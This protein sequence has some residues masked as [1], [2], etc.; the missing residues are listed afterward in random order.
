MI[1]YK[2]GDVL[3]A[4][5]DII[6]HGCNCSGGFGS[7][8]AAAVTK[9]Y[10]KARVRY[11]DKFYDE[12]WQLGDVQVVTQWDYKTV[13]NCATQFDYLPRGI[14]HADYSAIAKCMETIKSYAK[15]SNQS[16]AIPKIGAGLAGGD[17]NIILK[18]LED[19]FMDYDITVYEL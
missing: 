4:S 16:V 6:A 12:G 9:K 19:V 3:E 8:V 7:G 17:W 10:P 1:K 11:L 5:E 13:A 15:N 2:K 14:C 18:I